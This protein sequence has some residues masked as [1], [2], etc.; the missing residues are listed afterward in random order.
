MGEVT[1]GCLIFSL[2]LFDW[3]K[4]IR[5]RSIMDTIKNYDYGVHSFLATYTMQ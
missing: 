5:I 3:K 4:V 2:V 1:V